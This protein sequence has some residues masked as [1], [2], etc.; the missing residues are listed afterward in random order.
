MANSLN[1]ARQVVYPTVTISSGGTTSA[2]IDMRLWTLCGIHLPAAFTGA[3][4]TFSVATASGGTFDIMKD[5]TGASYSKT[6]AQGQYLP[7]NPAD[8]AGVGFLKIISGSTE[9]ADRVLTLA[10]RQII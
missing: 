8:F 2:E 4:L 1:V 3:A 5:G 6:I 9:G 7:L 10:V